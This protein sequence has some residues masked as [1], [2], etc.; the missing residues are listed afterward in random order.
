MEDPAPYFT[1]TGDMIRHLRKNKGITIVELADRMGV[2]QSYIV[3]LERNEIKATKEQIEV[4][5]DF[6]EKKL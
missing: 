5:T 6:L 2:A 3:R 4:I 1:S